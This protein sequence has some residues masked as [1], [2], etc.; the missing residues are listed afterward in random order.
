MQKLKSEMASEASLK[1]LLVSME[2][3][4]PIFSGN[5]VLARTVASSLIAMGKSAQKHRIAVVR[6]YVQ[7]MLCWFFRPFPLRSESIS[8][9]CNLTFKDSAMAPFLWLARAP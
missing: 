4:D 8:G 9:T 3:A 2:F 6:A 1:I 7:V 5:G